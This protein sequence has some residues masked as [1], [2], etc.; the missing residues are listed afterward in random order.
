MEELRS[1]CQIL[2]NIDFELP[3][4]PNEST[5]GKEDSAINFTRE[6]LAAELHFPVWSLVKQFLHFFGALPAL[7]HS[8][9]I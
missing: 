2:D 1:Y 3:D 8:N 4:D 9:V 6:Q 7:I 5:I